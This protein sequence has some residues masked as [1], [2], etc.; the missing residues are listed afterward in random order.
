MA[1]TLNMLVAAAVIVAATIA[2]TAAAA[3]PAC[4][5]PFDAELA[6][7]TFTATNSGGCTPKSVAATRYV[8]ITGGSISY[9]EVSPTG[10]RLQTTVLSYGRAWVTPTITTKDGR[11]RTVKSGPW[12]APA[13]NR[14]V[15]GL[16]ALIRAT[17]Q[18]AAGCSANRGLW[19]IVSFLRVLAY[20]FQL[21]AA[22][23]V[24][25]A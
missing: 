11:G 17:A 3:S 21:P 20:Q 15:A 5:T 16:S 1:P 9:D 4:F 23:G 24:C 6:G 25:A 8:T 12:G 19:G 10:V 7:R 18:M 2:T 22:A 14:F 13:R